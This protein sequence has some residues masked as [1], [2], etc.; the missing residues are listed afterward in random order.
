MV[1]QKWCNV[2]AHETNI[3][4]STT[5]FR[6]ALTYES[7]SADL[8]QQHLTINYDMSLHYL[9]TQGKALWCLQ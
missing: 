4:V 6:P 7:T 9:P 5:D 8:R 2:R 3:S 1:S